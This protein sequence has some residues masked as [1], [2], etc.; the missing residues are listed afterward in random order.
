MGFFWDCGILIELTCKRNAH[1]THQ[2]DNTAKV[3]I[4]FN[5]IFYPHKSCQSICKM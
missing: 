2:L 3:A 5:Y 1:H 4:I